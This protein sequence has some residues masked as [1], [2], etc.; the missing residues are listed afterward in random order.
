MIGVQFDEKKILA[1]YEKYYGKVQFGNRESEALF[2][3]TMVFNMGIPA[4]VAQRV[5]RVCK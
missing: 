5:V 3:E 1:N 2:F 4:G